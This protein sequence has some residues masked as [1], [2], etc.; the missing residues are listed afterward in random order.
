MPAHFV[1]N[2]MAPL[3]LLY[4]STVFIYLFIYLFFIVVVSHKLITGSCI[5][6]SDDMCTGV[7]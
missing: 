7:S 6:Y 3:V 5:F 2:V 1:V 4:L